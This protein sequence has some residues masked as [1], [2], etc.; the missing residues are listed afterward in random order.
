M[1][2]DHRR[3]TAVIELTAQQASLICGL[4]E[5]QFL[6]RLHKDDPPPKNA[7]G[8]YHSEELGEWLRR[9]E[10]LKLGL[11]AEA[12]GKLDP[13]QER[14]RKDMEMADKYELDNKVR[15]G[16]L[17]EASTVQTAAF[18]VVMRTRSRLLRVPS[19]V[20]PLVV[21]EDDRVTVQ[22]TI[23]DAIRDAL[24]ELSGQ[25]TETVDADS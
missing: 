21:G 3:E 5:R 9:Q 1:A 7:K 14:A 12:S 17:I 19:A 8:L 11:E 20:S 15:R 22:T 4:S 23:D 2:K 24:S 18:D 10:R 13:A 25:W 6:L 16:E